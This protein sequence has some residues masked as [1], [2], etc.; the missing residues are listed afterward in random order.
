MLASD[1]AGIVLVA[2]PDRVNLIGRPAQPASRPRCRA[3]QN[4]PDAVITPASRNRQMLSR[5]VHAVVHPRIAQML[6]RIAFRPNV[7][8][9][10]LWAD[11]TMMPITAAP[12]P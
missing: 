2:G 7:R 9:V 11:R 3:R 4:A 1:G 8:C 12:T 10:S 5:C 6:H